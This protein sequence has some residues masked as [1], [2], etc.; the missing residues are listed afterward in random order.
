M[1]RLDGEWQDKGVC[2]ISLAML[3]EHAEGVHL[4]L[5]PPRDLA[6]VFTIAVE[7]NVVPLHLPGPRRSDPLTA[8]FAGLLPHLPQQPP[9]APAPPRRSYLYTGDDIARIERLD[10]L[11]GST[12]WP[13]GHQ[14]CR[15]TTPPS[16]AR[17]RT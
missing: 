13:A 2:D 10:A 12:A 5:V 16:A 9:T 15:T 8:P 7:S 14:R 17:C 6:E 11:A 3:A 4:V 1:A